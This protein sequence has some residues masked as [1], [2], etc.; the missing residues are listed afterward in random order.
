MAHERFTLHHNGM[1][2]SE[3]MDGDGQSRIK[4]PALS[5]AA[6]FMASFVNGKAAM[7]SATVTSLEYYDRAVIQW[8]GET[9][10]QLH[11]FE[12]G[13]DYQDKG[14]IWA[15][16]KGDLEQAV[17]GKGGVMVRLGADH[18]PGSY[19]AEIYT[20]PSGLTQ[21]SG[22]VQLNVEAEVTQANCGRDITAQSLEVTG[23]DPLR[24][25]DLELAM[26]ACDAVGDFLVLKNMLNDLKIAQK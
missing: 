12:F 8:Q 9:G 21:Q 2:I 17:N 10:L 23:A 14:H 15:K 7:A 26:P 11:A 3:V 18:M 16:T 1:M 13:A 6:V 22:D 20:F 24:V 5:T 4:V 25:Q 19:M